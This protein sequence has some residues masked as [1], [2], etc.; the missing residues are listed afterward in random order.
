MIDYM[1][2]GSGKG[3]TVNVYPSAGMDEREL[4]NLVSRQ[5]AYQ[6]RRGAA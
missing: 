2:G 6:M 3:I 4:A 5:L 1:T